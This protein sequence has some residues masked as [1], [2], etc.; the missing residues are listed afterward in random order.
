MA[1]ILLHPYKYHHE[2]FAEDFAHSPFDGQT[3]PRR[4]LAGTRRR[5]YRTQAPLYRITANV[6]IIGGMG[7]VLAFV[8]ITLFRDIPSGEFALSSP[9]GQAITRALLIS[10]GMV[11]GSL[12]AMLLLLWLAQELWYLLV[13]PYLNEGVMLIDR[14]I[15]QPGQPLRLIYNQTVRQPVMLS[16]GTLELVLRE[17]VS[18]TVGTDTEYE[19]FDNVV[20]VRSFTAQ[21]YSAGDEIKLK[22]GYRL[23]AQ[24][25]LTMAKHNHRVGWL[26]RVSLQFEGKPRY[27]AFYQ[28]E[29]KA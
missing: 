1:K 24:A 18:R 10:I 25:P 3:I 23:P 26:L 28:V 6:L 17:S 14:P 13:G 22:A 4:A 29:V 2:S 19:H 15:A 12:P 11:V 21:R 9:E 20:F 27:E 5:M 16:E 7:A 8:F